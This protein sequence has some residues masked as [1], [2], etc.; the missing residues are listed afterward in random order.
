[1]HIHA[2]RDTPLTMIFGLS[3]MPRPH[4]YETENLKKL[5]SVGPEA[6]QVNPILQNSISICSA[7]SLFPFTPSH[8][9]LLFSYTRLPLTGA[10]IALAFR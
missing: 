1:M 2:V 5:W 8:C 3:Q 10:G 6:R 4:P 9:S 7:I